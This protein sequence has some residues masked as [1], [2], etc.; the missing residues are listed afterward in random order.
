MMSHFPRF[1]SSLVL[2]VTI[3][4]GF[5][6]NS[7]FLQKHASL[8]RDRAHIGVRLETLAVFHH[9]GRF[10]VR[11]PNYLHLKRLLGRKHMK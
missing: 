11:V 5:S 7:T 10:A 3:S 8:Q 1:F 2:N 9:F 4:Q 6:S